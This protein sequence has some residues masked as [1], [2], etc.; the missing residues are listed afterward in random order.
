MVLTKEQLSEFM[1]KHAEKENGLHDLFEIMLE[2]M[3]VAE[4]GEYLRGMSDGNKGNGYRQGHTYGQG[5][6]LEFRIPRDRYGNFHPQILAILRNQEEECEK[7]AGTLYTKGLTQSQ[8]G[9][10]FDEIYGEHYSK[11][12]ISRMIDYVRKD[13]SEWLERPLDEY[14]PIVFIDCVYIKVHRRR[15]VASESFYVVLGVTEDGTREVLGIFNRPAESAQGWGEMLEDLRERGVKRVGLVVADGL[16]GLDKVISMVFPSTPLQRCTTHLKRGMLGK[17]RHG[18]KRDLADDMRSV[19]RTGDCSY[20]VEQAWQNWQSLCDKWGKDYLSI[21][22]MRDDASYKA[23]FTYLNYSPRIQSMI[24]TTN[25]IERL[26]KDF[27]RVTRM[28]GAMPNEE[29]VLVL[30]GKTAMDKSS[31][32]RILPGIT[33]DRTLFPSAGTNDALDE[34]VVCVY[35]GMKENA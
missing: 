1:C 10:V 28:R 13:V 35:H 25:W 18:D 21:R 19:F 20:T 9:E 27:R 5:R 23:Y 11:A 29:S 24:Y 15:S 3:M 7:L 16:S 6:R 30:M 12:S 33:T 8:V 14:Y 17:V 26:Q 34:N 31:Y 2:S 32:N 4:R 22:R